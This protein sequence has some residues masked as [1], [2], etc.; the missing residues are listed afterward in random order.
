MLQ[1]ADLHLVR[2]QGISENIWSYAPVVNTFWC[3]TT[4]KLESQKAECY[5]LVVIYSSASMGLVSFSQRRRIVYELHALIQNF[6]S[7]KLNTKRTFL[8]NTSTL[9]E[10]LQGLTSQR[11][12]CSVD[13]VW[14]SGVSAGCLA[15]SL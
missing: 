8:K 6:F 5:F 11:L 4:S 15:T 2:F 7:T 10:M 9:A 13:G 14:F 3:A 1:L 12:T